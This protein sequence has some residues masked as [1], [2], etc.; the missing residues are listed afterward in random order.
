MTETNWVPT[1]STVGGS[2]FG[3]FAGQIIIG[4][5]DRVLKTPL[6]PTLA[7]AITG[8]CIFIAVYFIPDRKPP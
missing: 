8:I 5:C 7:G 6:D 2:A 4:I 1:Q 3:T